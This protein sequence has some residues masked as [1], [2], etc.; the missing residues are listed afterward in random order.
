MK[1]K[2]YFVKLK[3]QGKIDN[4]DFNTFLETV[5]DA[6]LPETVYAAIEENFLTKDRALNDKS[7]GG[8]IRSEVY[9]SV[10]AALHEILPSLNVF[11]AKD[12]SEEKDTFKKIKLFKTGVNESLE[13]AKT[14]GTPDNKVQEQQAKTIEEL[15]EKIKTIN[16]E[17]DNKVKEITENHTKEVAKKELN[18]A[19]MSKINAYT[20]ADEYSDPKR[21]EAATKFILLELE[22][23]GNHLS[24][25]DGQIVVS[26]VQ[27]GVPKPK[28]NGNEQVTIEKL[29]EPAVDP[30]IKRNAAPE[31]REDTNTRR[32]TP[33]T[34]KETLAELRRTNSASTSVN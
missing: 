26:E 34:G 6:E 14:T 18:H 1:L 24:L 25:K 22:S 12:I 9:D 3:E 32:E 33:S 13:K 31:K 21:K 2:D 16:T 4:E 30:F 28:F 20:F 15:T 19:L 10:D 5:P 7:I 8:K 17:Y 23:A 29:L 27:D 11:N